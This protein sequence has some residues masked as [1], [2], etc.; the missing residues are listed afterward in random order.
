MPYKFQEKQQNFNLLTSLVSEKCKKFEEKVKIVLRKAIKRN[1]LSMQA[2][3]SNLPN[4]Q[5]L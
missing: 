4:C 2:L 1:F 3:Y 5:P